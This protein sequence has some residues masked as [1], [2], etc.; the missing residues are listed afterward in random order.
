VVS[1]GGGEEV[2]DVEVAFQFERGPVEE[3]VAE[4]VGDGGG[5]GAEF[6][7]GGGVAGAEF[8]GNAVGAHGAPFVVIAL[9]PDFEEIGEGAIGG[10][11][12]GREVVVIVDDGL[13]CGDLVVEAASHGGVEEE[14]VV[15]EHGGRGREVGASGLGEEE[16]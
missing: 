4:R 14:V 12:C 7:V 1:G 13:A 11:V 5:E 2:V 8:F 3:R 10:D 16:A 15:N 6:V 9:E